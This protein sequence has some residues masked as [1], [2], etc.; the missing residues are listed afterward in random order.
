MISPNLKIE[1]RGGTLSGVGL[2][3]AA[4][5]LNA[6]NGELERK[7]FS[8]TEFSC[9]TT[10]YL[11]MPRPEGLAPHG[12]LIDSRRLSPLVTESRPLLKSNIV[13]L[14]S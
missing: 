14:R 1:F 12:F 11:Y 5:E 3:L 7:N 4:A 6:M 9:W 10:G 8:L 13:S 2:K